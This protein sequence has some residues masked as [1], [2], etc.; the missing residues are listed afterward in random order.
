MLKAL[1][2]QE[3]EKVNYDPYQIISSRRKQKKNAS[4]EHRNVEG[5]DN[6]TNLE[7][8]EGDQQRLDVFDKIQ[9]S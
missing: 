4:Y 8:F 7:N 1:Y 2:F 9:E 3:A 6:I 5:L